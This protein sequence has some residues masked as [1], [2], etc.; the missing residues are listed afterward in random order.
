MN[1]GDE[2]K[3]SHPYELIDEYEICTISEE[4]FSKL[5]NERFF[6]QHMTHTRSDVEFILILNPR[7][8]PCFNE[9][10]KPRFVFYRCGGLGEA[11]GDLLS[12]TVWLPL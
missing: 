9:L 8:R 3:V 7:I 1:I 11:V 6:V 10:H 2:V 12:L 5:C 4:L